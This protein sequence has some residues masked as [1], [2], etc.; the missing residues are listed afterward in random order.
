MS[1]PYT[2]EGLQTFP[3]SNVFDVF[4]FQMVPPYSNEGKLFSMYN[5]I[6][7][8][9]FTINTLVLL[10]VVSLDDILGDLLL[11]S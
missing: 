5:I 7:E 3:C 2:N 10:G 11:K 9:V 1:L 6:Y 4:P 8:S